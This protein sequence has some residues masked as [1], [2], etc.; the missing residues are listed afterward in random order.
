[1]NDLDRYL[2]SNLEDAYD[3]YGEQIRN[4]NPGS[5][6]DIKRMFP[7]Q[8]DMVL[9]QWAAS[10]EVQTNHELVRGSIDAIR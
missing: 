2:T 7:V 4:A 3:R 9:A 8:M 5:I 10:L 6:E 1:M